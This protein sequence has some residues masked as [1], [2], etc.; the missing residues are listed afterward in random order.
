ERGADA[1][2]AAHEAEA[3]RAFRV[4]RARLAFEREHRRAHHRPAA[5][6]AVE[7]A[8]AVLRPAALHGAP[9]PLA[10]RGADRRGAVGV[11]QA[12]AADA[13]PAIADAEPFPALEARRAGARL[14]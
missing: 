3:A 10:L 1:L 8:R 7:A 13:L 9:P 12:D 4:A 11:V 14:R 6:H 2:L 5:R